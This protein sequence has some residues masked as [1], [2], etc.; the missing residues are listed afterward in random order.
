M[1]ALGQNDQAFEH[2]KT[3]LGDAVSKKVFIF[4]SVELELLAHL[5]AKKK[6]YEKG[7]L[8]FSRATRFR[9]ENMMPVPPVNQAF[10]NETLNRLRGASN[11][12]RFEMLWTKGE[13]MTAQECLVLL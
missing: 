13:E 7:V 3:S 12:S 2:L 8:L 4:I 6:E 5:L 9:K 11:D 10:Y 1:L